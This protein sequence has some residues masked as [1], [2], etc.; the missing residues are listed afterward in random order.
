MTHQSQDIE[1]EFFRKIKMG[2]D[3]E[4]EIDS[5]GFQAKSGNFI[6]HLGRRRN[7]QHVKKKQQGKNRDE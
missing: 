3:F 6:F 1:T 5:G 7:R 4:T 2:K